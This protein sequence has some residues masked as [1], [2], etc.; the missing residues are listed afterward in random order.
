MKPIK[1]LSRLKMVVS[2]NDRGDK[3]EPGSKRVLG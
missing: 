1:G 3:N 2:H